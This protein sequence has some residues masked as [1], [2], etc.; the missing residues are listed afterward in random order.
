MKGS[1]ILSANLN[2]MVTPSEK[3]SFLERCRRAERNPSE[4]LRSLIRMAKITKG[5][6]IEEP[7]E[8]LVG[9]D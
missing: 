7:A 9:A 6:S 8:E 2:V 4:V 1:E 3:A 5:V